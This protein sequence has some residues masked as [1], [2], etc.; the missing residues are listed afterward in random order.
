MT[1]SRYRLPWGRFIPTDCAG[2][3]DAP[4]LLHFDDLDWQG[5]ATALAS[6][7]S[8]PFPGR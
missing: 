2:T 3:R 8:Q 4:C 7:G 1:A 6:A 5:R